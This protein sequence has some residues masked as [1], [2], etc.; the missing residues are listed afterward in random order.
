MH[1]YTFLHR[2]F[3][4]V[5]L[6]L[7]SIT[8][9]IKKKSKIKQSP[10]FKAIKSS[11]FNSTVF[12]ILLDFSS[13][14]CVHSYTRGSVVLISMNLSKKMRRIS[15]PA[16]ASSSTVEA[17]VLQ[18]YQPGEEGLCS[19]C[20]SHLN[21]VIYLWESHNV[22]GGNHIYLVYYMMCILNIRVP[23]TTNFACLLCQCYDEV[24]ADFG[25]TLKWCYTPCPVS[26]L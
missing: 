17:F 10:S 18:S 11:K 15:V 1:K 9:C 16:L 13:C 22:M 5:W 20:L 12:F 6:S 14:L 8:Y 3:R 25:H 4:L 26:V 21:A 24:I 7:S 19:R 23:I 2:V